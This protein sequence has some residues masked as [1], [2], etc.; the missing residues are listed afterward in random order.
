EAVFLPADLGADDVLRG[1]RQRDHA[2]AG[3]RALAVYIGVIGP[4]DQPVQ[5]AGQEGQRLLVVQLNPRDGG[6]VEIDRRFH[7]VEQH[8]EIGD[9][10]EDLGGDVVVDPL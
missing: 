10:L 6:G 4:D 5:Q 1:L 7:L 2:A 8:A 3:Q 9:V